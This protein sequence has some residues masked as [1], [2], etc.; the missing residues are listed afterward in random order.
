MECPPSPLLVIPFLY[1]CT[2]CTFRWINWT[3]YWTQW[4]SQTIIVL[5][6]TLLAV[7]G[8][9]KSLNCPL[10]C[11]WLSFMYYLYFSAIFPTPPPP[12]FWMLPTKSTPNLEMSSMPLEWPSK[13]TS[14]RYSRRSQDLY[15]HKTLNPEPLFPHFTPSMWRTHLNLQALWKSVNLR[16]F[17]PDT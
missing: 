11:T 15:W 12:T 5:A 10:H 6:C 16:T 9:E 4:N 14:L 2:F 13:W 8:M 7:Q 1:L 3:S 17:L